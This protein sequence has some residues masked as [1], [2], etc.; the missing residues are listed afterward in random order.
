M[1]VTINKGG[2]MK[3]CKYIIIKQQQEG[4]LFNNSGVDPPS[5][6]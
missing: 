2:E 6:M 1:I 3:R 4:I 5:L